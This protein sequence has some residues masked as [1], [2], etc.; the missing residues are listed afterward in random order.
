MVR[1]PAP[2]ILLIMTAV[3]ILSTAC[4]GG[5]ASGDLRAFVIEDAHKVTITNYEAQLAADSIP[6]VLRKDRD[7]EAHKANIEEFVWPF[8]REN[9][10]VD[11]GLYI[12][13]PS[14]DY[15]LHRGRFDFQA[16]EEGFNESPRLTPVED[17]FGNDMNAWFTE[18]DAF[19]FVLLAEHSLVITGVWRMLEALRTA[20][21]EGTGFADE[22]SGIG[23]LLYGIDPDA[24]ESEI[25]TDCWIT[26]GEKLSLEGCVG[27]SWSVSGDDGSAQTPYAVLFDSPQSAE[28]ALPEIREEMEDTARWF[29]DSVELT[30][31]EID[32]E[33]I[34]FKARHLE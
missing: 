22:S 28:A 32:G 5:Q 29:E 26:E 18:D 3:L 30:D 4:V 15:L 24:L 16:I 8:G 6:K 19:T 20:F 2:L 17:W 1:L 21:T 13:A 14:G 27:A 23:R 12:E 33:M 10:R 34:T 25:T 9:G 11:Q 31:V 7:T